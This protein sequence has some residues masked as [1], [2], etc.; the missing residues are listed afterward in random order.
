MKAA[1]AIDTWKLSI[2]ERHL[3]QAGYSYMKGDGVTED[4]LLL[5]VI[6]DNVEALSGVVKAANSEAAQTKGAR[7]G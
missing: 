4:T 5:T 7:G 6:T 3:K 2:F 1:I